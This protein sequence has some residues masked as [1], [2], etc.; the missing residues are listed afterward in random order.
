M[1]FILA[2]VTLTCFPVT[3][4]YL[5]YYNR[6]RNQ[7]EM[8]GRAYKAVLVVGSCIMIL[9]WLAIIAYSGFGEGVN[10]ASNL[11]EDRLLDS[12]IAEAPGGSLFIPHF[13]FVSAISGL[14]AAVVGVAIFFVS[15]ALLR[16]KDALSL[17]WANL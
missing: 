16:T 17:W 6:N 11:Q 7:G 12:D 15:R 14:G 13:I 1:L 5:A 10:F 8:S 2:A 4:L 9:A 3:V